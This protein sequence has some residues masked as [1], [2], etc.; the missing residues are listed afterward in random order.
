[1]CNADNALDEAQ[2]KIPILWSDELNVP[3]DFVPL[4]LFEDS[5]NRQ[6]VPITRY[7]YHEQSAHLTEDQPRW[8]GT[9]QNG[10]IISLPR[11]APGS[12][13]VKEVRLLCRCLLAIVRDL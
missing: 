2:V 8:F 13:D 6:A 10:A 4:F 9:L 1:M 11:S 3:R 5:H 12:R 7:R